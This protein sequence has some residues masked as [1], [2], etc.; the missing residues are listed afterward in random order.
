MLFL[1]D[2]VVTTSSILEACG[3]ELLKVENLKLSIATIACA[4]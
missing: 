4:E 2:D 3:I 1:V